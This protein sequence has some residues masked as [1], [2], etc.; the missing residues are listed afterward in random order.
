MSL[1]LTKLISRDTDSTVY[2]R[3]TRD[4]REIKRDSSKFKIA[5]ILDKHHNR[6]KDPVMEQQER[7]EVLLRKSKKPMERRNNNSA[8]Q[9]TDQQEEYQDDNDST[10]EEIDVGDIAPTQND[11]VRH[12]EEQQQRR[13]D[14]TRHRLKRLNDYITSYHT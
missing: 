3:R 6:E 10:G 9:V 14:K 13:S 5:N 11:D 12:E 1:E 2:A 7:Q 8:D 4:G